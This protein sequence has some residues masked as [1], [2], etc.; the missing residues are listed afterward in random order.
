MATGI[1]IAVT[2]ASDVNRHHLDG[3]D[4]DDDEPERPRR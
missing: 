4:Q 2:H 3:D 1:A